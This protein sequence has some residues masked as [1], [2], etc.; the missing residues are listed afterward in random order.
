MT[1]GRYSCFTAVLPDS[2]LM[3]VGGWTGHDKTGA[4]E[5][6]RVCNY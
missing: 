4:V 6:A 1:T 3:V 5:I 2:Q